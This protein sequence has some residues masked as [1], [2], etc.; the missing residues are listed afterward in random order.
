MIEKPADRER[1]CVFFDVTDRGL[2]E[3]LRDLKIRPIGGHVQWPVVWKSLGIG[4]DQDPLCHKDLMAP[5]MTAK[6][7]AAFCGVTSRTVYRWQKGQGLPPGLP[8]MP[9]VIDL[10]VGRQNARKSRWRT[11]E[12]RAWQNCEPQPVYA[13]ATPVFGSLKPTK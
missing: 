11:A 7:V 10:S 1:L 3:L 8:P 12:I 9:T 4:P 6:K 2:T 13:R 5:L